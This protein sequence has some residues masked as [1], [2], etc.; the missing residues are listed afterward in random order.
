MTNDSECCVH[1]SSKDTD[2]E[3][4][5]FSLWEGLETDE[6]GKAAGPFFYWSSEKKSVLLWFLGIVRWRGKR[7]WNMQTLSHH[8]Y[9]FV[10]IYYCLQISVS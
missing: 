7:V 1:S 4:Y 10:Y 8:V 2:T 6:T 3:K 9:E 5:K